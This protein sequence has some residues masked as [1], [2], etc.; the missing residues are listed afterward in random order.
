[1]NVNSESKVPKILFI[2]DKIRLP[3]SLKHVYIRKRRKDRPRAIQYSHQSKQ[4]VMGLCI[5]H[6]TNNAKKAT[7]KEPHIARKG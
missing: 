2:E 6:L 5:T 4:L 7:I 3:R 1:M